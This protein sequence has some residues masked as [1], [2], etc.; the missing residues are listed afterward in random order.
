MDVVR[1]I[2]V[3][4]LIDGLGWGGAEMLLGDFAAGAA[5]AG[6]QLSVG[7]LKERDGSPAAARLRAQGVEPVQVPVTR[8]LEPSA[9]RTVRRHL[10]EVRPDVVHTHLGYSDFLGGIA[11]RSLGVPAVSTMHITEWEWERGRRDSTKLLLF[12]RARRH[13]MGRV[14]TVS[15]AMRASYLRTGWDRPH[16]VVTVHNGIVGRGR[17][18]SSPAV[19]ASLGLGPE[20]VVLAMVT[21]LRIGK[22]HDVAVAAVQEL[23]VRFPDVRL[24]ILGDGPDR[25]EIQRLAARLGDAVVLAG[26]RDDVMAVLDAV[27]VLVH[28]SH[29]DALPT[30]LLEAMAAAVPVVATSVGGI[31]E[32]VVHRRTGILVEAPPQPRALA[33]ALVPLLLDRELRRRL[34][35]AGR[36]RFQQHF[37][38]ERWA[39]RTRVVYDE[40]LRDATRPSGEA[41]RSRS[42]A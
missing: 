19:R 23:L 27:D 5:T 1:P 18:G 39:E 10:A 16:R 37:T 42:R 25:S 21:V 38:A 3:H 2:R 34:G 36:A 32:I 26:H 15:E 4:A 17:P 28:P 14:I 8:L 31:P 24:L 30:A 11:A 22:G 7:F 40:L 12:A 20:H 6:I 9:L 41:R 29:V 33:D 35:A 13:C